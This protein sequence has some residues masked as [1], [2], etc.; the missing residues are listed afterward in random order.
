[1]V[2]KSAAIAVIAG[3]AGVSLLHYACL[4]V[5]RDPRAGELFSEF[6]RAL[7]RFEREASLLERELTWT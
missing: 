4:A 6:P 1:M 5:R 7:R 2:A 3:A